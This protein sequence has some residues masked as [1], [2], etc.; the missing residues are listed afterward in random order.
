MFSQANQSRLDI[1]I[2][3]RGIEIRLGDQIINKSCIVLQYDAIAAG[4]SAL[5]QLIHIAKDEG[6]LPGSV[7]RI[8]LN[9]DSTA[10]ANA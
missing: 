3:A 6:K 8:A 5:S 1:I 4:D 10:C 2:C 9:D 7:P